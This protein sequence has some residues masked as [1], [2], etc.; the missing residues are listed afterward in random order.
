[1]FNAD[2]AETKDNKLPVEDCRS[3]SSS[4]GIVDVNGTP[5]WFMEYTEETDPLKL[6][7]P[8][9]R[10]DWCFWGC[11][12][13][14]SRWHRGHNST[15]N[16]HLKHRAWPQFVS[17]N[18]RCLPESYRQWHTGHA[19]PWSPPTINAETIEH[20]EAGLLGFRSVKEKKTRV[21]MT[22]YYCIIQQCILL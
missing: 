10:L 19:W 14:V 5:L 11:C 3:K 6:W 13:T 18:F 4:S 7:N 9:S 22:E 8:D 16:M 15:A 1:M 12:K 17:T 2:W 21:V 20:A